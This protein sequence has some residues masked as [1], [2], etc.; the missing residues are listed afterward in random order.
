[1]VDAHRRHDGDEIAGDADR[2]GAADPGRREQ[3][4]TEG[5]AEHPA[6]IVGP[7]IEG[8]R[9]A[10][11]VGSGHFPD[12]FVSQP[13]FHG[14]NLIGFSTNI[15]HHTDVGGARRPAIGGC[16]PASNGCTP[17]SGWCA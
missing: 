7:D 1:M 2:K 6:R 10:H 12:F 3:H 14:G 13:A 9:P 15:V 17:A 11:P 8:H 16:T 5:R 4:A